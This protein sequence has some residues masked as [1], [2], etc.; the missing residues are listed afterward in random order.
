LIADFEPLS[1]TGESSTLKTQFCDPKR[2]D[3]YHVGT[4]GRPASALAYAANPVK[5]ASPAF[6]N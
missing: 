4:H 3:G 5:M 1:A 2:L 6:E